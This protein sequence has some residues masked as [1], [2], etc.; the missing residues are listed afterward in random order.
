[1]AR[2]I[3]P[4]DHTSGSATASTVGGAAWGGFKWG[5]LGTA[6]FIIGM[7]AL[8]A[9]GLPALVA[10][11]PSIS[12]ASLGAFFTSIGAI[13]A[14]APLLAIGG[15]IAGFVLGVGGSTVVAPLA[16]AAGAV[17]GGVSASRRVER[18]RTAAKI[19]Q[20]QTAMEQ[21][22]AVIIAD[23][24]FNQAGSRIQAD[25]AEYQGKLNQMQLQRS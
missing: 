2:D 22:Q 12:T 8:G 5:I 6:A 10:V 7:T 3:T 19:I 9:W 17:G 15:G 16:T 25:S 4:I 11:L 13:F 1:M 24:R 20:A 14:E 18:E 21:P 23:P